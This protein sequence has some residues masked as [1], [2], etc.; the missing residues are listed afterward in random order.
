MNNKGFVVTTVGILIA[1][2]V[3]VFLLFVPN[4]ASESIGLGIRPNKTITSTVEK[5]DLLKNPDGTVIGTKTT[6][7]A[8]DKDIQQHVTFWEWLSS[9]PFLAVVFMGLGVV[10]PVVGVF[11]HK[12]WSNAVAAYNDL[13]GETKRIVVSV[14]AGL[15]TIQ[16]P[17]V[18]QKFLDALSTQQDQSTKDLVKE[19]L[20]SA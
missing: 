16:D 2:V 11:L 4:K 14:K 1:V 15:A 18:K 20:K 8:S 10:F 9:L 19:L 12:M 17:L 7:C 5:V 3:G 6:T 13:T